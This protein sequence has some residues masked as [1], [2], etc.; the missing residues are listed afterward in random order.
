MVVPIFSH[1]N[2]KPSKIS[3]CIIS[4]SLTASRDFYLRPEKF[5]IPPLFLSAKSDSDKQF[6][7]PKVPQPSMEIQMH[8]VSATNPPHH[9]ALH[10]MS[11]SSY[12]VSTKENAPLKLIL[13]FCDGLLEG[14]KA[15][16]FNFP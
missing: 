12:A 11:G 8:D 15:R 3:S 7:F 2:H 5:L 4:N 13:P 9:V 10:N 1:R 6:V 16:A 14:L